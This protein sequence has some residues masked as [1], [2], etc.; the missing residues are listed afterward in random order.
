MVL[1]CLMP[2]RTQLALLTARAQ[3]TQ[4]QLTIKQDVQVPFH[5]TALQPLI[6]QSIYTAR[7]VLSQVQKLSFIL[8]KLHMVDDGPSL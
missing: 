1:L 6:P 2:L 8:V 5:R 3:L 7:V 4:I